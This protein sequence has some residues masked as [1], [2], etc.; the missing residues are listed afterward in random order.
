[1]ISNGKKPSFEALFQELKDPSSR[2]AAQRLVGLSALSAPQTALLQDEW[3]AFADARR[4]TLVHDLVELAEDNVELNFDSVFMIA[5]TDPAADVRR[6]AIQGLWEHD[7]PDLIAPLVALLEHDAD[8]GVR[9]DAALALGRFVIQAELDTLSTGDAGRVQQA[10][11]RTF[12]DP[13][14]PV[15]VRARA[16]E[17]IGARSEEWVSA[18][19]DEAFDSNDRRLR[20]S[21]VHAMG[22]SADAAWLSSVLAQLESDDAEMRFEAAT[23]AGSIAEQEA[24]PYLLPLLNDEDSEVRMATIMALSEI[25][26]EEAKDALRE[27]LSTSSAG[28]AQA[29]RDALAEIEFADDPLA[30]D[31]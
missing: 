28:S 11:R 10:L 2:V 6:E 5:L 30:F 26:G 24:T 18:L 23:A 19:I 16:L 21:A 4:K 14:E 9:A 8:P 3:P 27:L 31:V 25:G 15:E 7:S 22:R 20:I 1:M 29:I 13:T 12:H 17:S